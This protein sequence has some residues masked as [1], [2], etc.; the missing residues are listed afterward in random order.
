MPSIH[1][2]WY[3]YHRMFAKRAT[4]AEEEQ[5]DSLEVRGSAGDVS[6]VYR[7][8]GAESPGEADPRG[9]LR[10]VARIRH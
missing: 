10:K 4:K 6:S 1:V 5:N 2:C 3:I 7:I 8:T 9:V